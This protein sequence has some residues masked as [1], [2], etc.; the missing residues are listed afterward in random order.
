MGYTGRLPINVAYPSPYDESLSYLEYLGKLHEK[1]NEL[2]TLVNS[3]EKDYTQYTDSE[4]LKLK[5]EINL[6]FNSVFTLINQKETN[7]QGLIESQANTLRTEYTNLISSSSNTINARITTELSIVN[8]RITNEI[9]DVR[10]Y[11]D[12]GFINVIVLNPVTGNTGSIQD[13]LNSLS[14]QFRA[15]ALTCSAYDSLELTSSVYD[16][17]E[18][19]AYEYDYNGV[20]I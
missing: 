8:N 19:T 4:I 1:I 10:S 5:N 17:L 20:T 14:E 16:A 6:Q 13:A 11:I 3:Y 9:N 7:L 15:N 2:I 12:N 18:L